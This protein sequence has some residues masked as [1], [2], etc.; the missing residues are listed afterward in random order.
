MRTFHSVQLIAVSKTENIKRM[1]KFLGRQSGTGSAPPAQPVGPTQ[2]STGTRARR[3]SAT[4]RTPSPDRGNS[5]PV[6]AAVDNNNNNN[7][8]SPDVPTGRLTAVVESINREYLKTRGIYG[9]AVLSRSS[10]S[11]IHMVV[12][13]VPYPILPPVPTEA[14]NEVTDNTPGWNFTDSVE[15]LVGETYDIFSLIKQAWKDIQALK[16]E[17][18]WYRS[19]DPGSEY[20]PVLYADEIQN[21][22]SEVAKKTSDYLAR[23]NKIGDVLKILLPE[24]NKMGIQRMPTTSAS[25]A[26]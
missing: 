20:I 17:V 23:G 1:W 4:G 7:N 3:P 8:N 2:V 25:P 21:R 16:Q 6:P 22:R 9:Q 26:S 12:L 10:M 14:R 19:F 15:E 13:S 24:L 11:K 18:E 5:D